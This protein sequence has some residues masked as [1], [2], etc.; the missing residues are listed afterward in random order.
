LGCVNPEAAGLEPSFEHELGLLAG[1]H[2]Q[3]DR[4]VGPR[5][6]ERGWRKAPC[7]RAPTAPT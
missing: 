2:C 4:P 5:E 6:P 1:R 3:M 7:K